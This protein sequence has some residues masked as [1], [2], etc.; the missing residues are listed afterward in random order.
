MKKFGFRPLG[1]PD[2]IQFRQGNQI[3]NRY[4]MMGGSWERSILH[5]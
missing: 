4:A 3:I 1:L 5:G 2:T